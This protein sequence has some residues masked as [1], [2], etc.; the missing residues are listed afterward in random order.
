[1]NL[2]NTHARISFPEHQLDPVQYEHSD[3]VVQGFVL[4][5]FLV[6]QIDTYPVSITEPSFHRFTI[7]PSD[8]LVQPMKIVSESEERDIASSNSI[9]LPFIVPNADQGVFIYLPF[10]AIIDTIILTSDLRLAFTEKGVK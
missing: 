2:D 7:M 1:M 6:S 10:D 9:R 5:C 3:I 4:R 8:V